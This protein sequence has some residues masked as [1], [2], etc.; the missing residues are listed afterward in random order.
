MVP[1]GS[2]LLRSTP[3]CIIQVS[4]SPVMARGPLETGPRP[5]QCPTAAVP[6]HLNYALPVHLVRELADSGLTD[7]GPPG[8]GLGGLEQKLTLITLVLKGLFTPVPSA[9]GR[10]RGGLGGLTGVGTSVTPPQ[11]GNRAE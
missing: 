1:C 10:S 2:A 8:G 5:T 4:D 3:Q 9:V 7:C 6:C 11:S